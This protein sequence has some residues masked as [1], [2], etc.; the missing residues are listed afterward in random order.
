LWSFATTGPDD[1]L[2]PGSAYYGVYPANHISGKYTLYQAARYGARLVVRERFSVERFWDDVREHDVTAAALVGPM[3]P[4][5]MLAPERADDTEHPLRYVMMAPLAPEV[6]A[7]ERRFDVQVGT[8]YGM[9]EIGIV[10]EARP[11]SLANGTSCGRVRGGWPGYEVRIVDEH[12][13]PVP[14]G[15]VGELVVRSR[16]PWAINLGYDGMPEAGVAA[17]RNGWFHTGDGFRTDADD[18]FYFVDRMKDTIRRRGENI[19][20]FEVEACV[21]AHPDVAECA[22][23]AVPSEYTEDDVKVC[24]VLRDRAS[25]A[26]EELVEFLVPRIPPFMV[27]RYIELVDALPKTEATMRTQKIKLRE[28]PF[29]EHTWDREDPTAMEP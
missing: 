21:L 18:N 12:D 6:E 3:A 2:L 16:D 20:S 17:W 24:V 23:I 26:P 4:F 15:H 5:L 28:N 22:A 1:F 9:S 27:P 19:S 10:F 13:A 7:F 29:N 11:G 14:A 8:G 25:L